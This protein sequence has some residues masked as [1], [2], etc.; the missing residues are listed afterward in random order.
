MNESRFDIAIPEDEQKQVAE[1]SA[2]INRAK[3][4]KS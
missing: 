3:K 1:A 2:A 4:Q